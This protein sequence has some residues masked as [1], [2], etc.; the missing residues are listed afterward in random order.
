VSRSSNEALC[1][2]LRLGIDTTSFLSSDTGRC[3][4]LSDQS[5]CP[6]LYLISLRGTCQSRQHCLIGSPLYPEMGA[7]LRG[8]VASLITSWR[9][10]LLREYHRRGSEILPKRPSWRPRVLFGSEM[11]LA[12]IYGSG[13]SLAVRTRAA[14]GRATCSARS[15]ACTSHRLVQVRR[16]LSERRPLLKR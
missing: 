9:G 3:R 12:H 8:S 16:C 10:A 4:A 11:A 13:L 5:V 2:T 15:A 6:I 7:D 1:L 14:S